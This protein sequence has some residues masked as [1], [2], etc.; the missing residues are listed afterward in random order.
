MHPEADDP[1]SV[2]RVCRRFRRL[3]ANWGSEQREMTEESGPSHSSSESSGRR[4]LY[5]TIDSIM[6]RD[7]RQLRLSCGKLLKAGGHAR[8]TVHL[9]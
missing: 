8:D 2:A 9:T 6:K 7:R 4:M 1:E 3:V 5:M